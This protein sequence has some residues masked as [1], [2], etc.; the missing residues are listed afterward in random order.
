MIGLDDFAELALVTSIAAIAVRVVTPDEL[1]I[2][3]A[4]GFEVGL[5]AKPKDGKR[6]LLRSIEALRNFMS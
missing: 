6:P 5:F 2:A 1:R 4:Y 3:V